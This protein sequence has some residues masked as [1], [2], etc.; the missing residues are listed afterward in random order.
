MPLTIDRDGTRRF[1]REPSRQRRRPGPVVLATF[2]STPFHAESERLA[3]EAAAEAGAALFLVD[4][5]EVRPGRRGARPATDAVPS[6]VAAALQSPA[7]LARELGVRCA[8]M[9]VP[10]LN[11]VAA[12]VGVVR[13]RQAAL[14]V[15]G[16][17][18][19][20]LR[21]FRRP[22]RRRFGE[23]KRALARHVPCLLWS[24]PELVRTAP[25]AAAAWTRAIPST[26]GVAADPS[27][28]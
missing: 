14:V 19:A 13:E 21:R 10:S 15:F 23:L 4:L 9:R 8:S 3:V 17:D 24:A 25:P 12:L 26:F 22:S 11:P 7:V 28:A 18:P 6:E 27:G 2:G 20:L 1:V 16:P 5:V